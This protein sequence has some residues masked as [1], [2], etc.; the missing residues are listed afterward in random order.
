MGM[1]Q[2]FGRKNIQVGMVDT[3]ASFSAVNGGAMFKNQGANSPA[4]G[5]GLLNRLQQLFQAGPQTGREVCQRRD[6]LAGQEQQTALQ[7]RTQWWNHHEVVIFVNDPC[8][9][10]LLQVLVENRLT[11]TFQFD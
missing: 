5:Q 1:N 10:P 2:N 7:E 9:Q 6:M 8:S 4:G 3:T 11:F